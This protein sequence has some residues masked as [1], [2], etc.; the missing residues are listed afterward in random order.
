MNRH[1]GGKLGRRPGK[2]FRGASWRGGRWS[3]S[4]ALLL[5]TSATGAG[6]TAV[7]EFTEPRDGAVYST[8]DEI[9]V[10]LRAAD[11]NDVF[12]S[13]EVLVDGHV[14]GTAQY[15]CSWCPCPNP[16]DGLETTP[17]LP[18]PWDGELPPPPD[19]WRGW[20][21]GHPGI[22]RLTARATGRNGT[23]VQ[24]GPITIV[25]FD[26]HPR[27]QVGADGKGD[28]RPAGRIPRARW[29]RSGSQRRSPGL[30]PPRPHSCQA[31]WPPSM[32]D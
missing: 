23:V 4:L 3:I 20:K 28:H 8:L 24:T 18:T 31:P 14:L 2:E 29:I 11:A 17:R 32:G 25:V 26:P 12:L 27:L 6:Q 10:A 5:L 15:C 13:A 7:L 1:G 9:P 16:P 30:E 19:Q 21:P 22:F